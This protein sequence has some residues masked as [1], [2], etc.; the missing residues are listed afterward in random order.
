[1]KRLVSFVLVIALLFSCNISALAVDEP[2]DYKII[3][4]EVEYSDNVGTGEKLTFMQKD[5]N[6]YVSATELATRLGYSIS[7]QDEFVTIYNTTDDELPFGF[8]MFYF[9]STKVKHTIFSQMIDDYEAPFQSIKDGDDAWIPF[10]FA[11]LILGSAVSVIDNTFCIDIPEKSIVDV[12]YIVMSN[13]KEYN[14]DWEDDFGYSNL[15]VD[16]IGISSHI[17]NL[18]NGI[19]K[20]DGDSWAELFQAFAND[21]S[22][23][24]SKYGEDIALLLCTESDKELEA[25]TKKIKKYK[26]LLSSDGKIGKMLSQYSKYLD[27]DATAWADTCETI[28]N[29]VQSGNSSMAQYNKA[30][31]ALEKAL[32]K[33]TWFSNTGGT[34]LEVQKGIKSAVPFLDALLTAMEVVGYG[35]EFKNQDEFSINAVNMALTNLNE[36]SLTCETMKESMLDYAENLQTD[37]LTYSTKRYFDQNVDSWIKKALGITELLGTQA[38]IELIAWSLMSSFV[39]QLSD[40]LSAADKFE[41]ALYASVFASD[42][43]A[44][45][46]KMRN[47]V[48]SEE[49]NMTA[50]NLYT[51]SQYCYI[52][53]KSC[54]ITR[55]AALASLKG[56][57]SSVQEQIQPLIDEQ[58][59]INEEIAGLLVRLKDA[60]TSNEKLVYGFLPSDN[61]DYLSSY[62]AS[63]WREVIESSNYDGIFEVLP[64][65]FDFSSG[66]GGW[67]THLDL[68]PD[69]TF[70]GQYYDSD[71]GD[72]GSGYTNGT[73]YI[74]NFDGKF[75]KPEQVNEYTYSMNLE[76]LNTEGALGDEY[77]E[78]NTRYI[79]SSPYGFDNANEFLIYLP[80]IRISDLPDGFVLWLYA[81]LDVRT[82]EILPYYGIYNV[83]GEEGFVAYSKIE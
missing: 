54:Y 30:Y 52:Y 58:N 24:D 3:S 41:L 63:V 74:C 10:E 76:Y 17:A 8:T 60:N 16:V 22:A 27:T 50:E 73:V 79:Y 1:M 68:N 7:V 70:T 36:D 28:L 51:V 14:F 18:F 80:G 43:F 71:M 47:N 44:D 9:D 81:F 31:Q 75:S 20:F 33:Q 19:L 13:F 21:S 34:I 83:G 32:D 4:L 65:S 35:E 69:G 45:Y 66:S 48:F 72:T 77:Y 2:D 82:T 56:K 40:S 38:N 37:V 67:R 6:V 64:K 42:M 55:D 49:E 25:E 11:L 53:L 12:F 57:S 62:D 61:R 39:P 78:N 59:A 46:Q 26:D 29:E 5:D 15:D 23:Y